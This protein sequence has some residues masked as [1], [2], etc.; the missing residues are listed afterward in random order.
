[1]LRKPK[2]FN[3]F[4][5]A[6]DKLKT[7]CSE[8]FREC[9]IP[10]MDGRLARAQ[11]GRVIRTKE[12]PTAK[13]NRCGEIY[14]GPVFVSEK[15]PWPESDGKHMLPL[16]QINLDKW[17]R[18]MKMD[19]GTGVLQVWASQ[20]DIWGRTVRVL[21]PEDVKKEYLVREIP[22]PV[23][24][25]KDDSPNSIPITWRENDR[26]TSW[27]ITGYEKRHFA[28]QLWKGNVNGIVESIKNAYKPKHVSA[29]MSMQKAKKIKTLIAKFKKLGMEA[30]RD[31]ET[32]SDSIGGSFSPIQ[33]FAY[34]RPP[35][36]MSIGTSYEP[37]FWG[38]SGNAQLFYEKQPDG[39][40]EYSFD[41][42]CS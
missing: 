33:Y 3:D 9:D 35:V 29:G 5:K 26:G 40:F 25:I 18:I 8:S 11:W 16:F 1:M 6:W 7:E 27:A 20:V 14:C 22:E 36:L 31:F 15:H 24:A 39:S 32:Q 42:S 37:Y 12:I 17:G 21:P 41:W 13:L 30:V 34:E 23:L 28:V 4:V 19:F 10:D 38:D 2:K